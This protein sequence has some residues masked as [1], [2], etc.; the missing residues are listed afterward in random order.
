METIRAPGVL[1]PDMLSRPAHDTLARSAPDTL[2][3]PAHNT[4]A[5]AD[6]TGIIQNG[7]G[8]ESRLLRTVP[9]SGGGV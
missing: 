4:L 3:R 7:T 2:S 5:A 9:G 8:Q 6:E 1:A